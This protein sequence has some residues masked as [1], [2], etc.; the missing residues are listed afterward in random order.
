VSLEAVNL[1]VAYSG[2][3]AIHDVSVRVTPGQVVALVGPNGAGK[4][5]L[6]KAICGLVRVRSGRV[7]LDGVDVTRSSS[8]VRA[9]KGVALVPEGRRVF[10]SMTVVENLLVPLDAVRSRDKLGKINRAFEMFNDLAI[11]RDKKAGMLSGGQQQMLAVARA[12]MLEP[13]VLVLDEPTMGLAPLVVADVLRVARELA[14]GGTSV[15]IADESARR[16]L[17]VADKVYAYRSGRLI[18]EGQ[19]G[20]PDLELE[21]DKAYFN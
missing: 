11:A 6:V 12:L 17:P 14:D 16:L 2:R 4:S 5:S 8:Q 1:T 19:S 3:V 20:M 18:Y 9:R 13:R 21:I 15:I 7:L 10:A